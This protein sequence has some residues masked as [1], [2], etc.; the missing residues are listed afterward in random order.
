MSVLTYFNIFVCFSLLT[1]ICAQKHENIESILKDKALASALI[2]ISVKDISSNE[3][4]YEKNSHTQCTPASIFKIITTYAALEKLGADFKFKTEIYYSG[5]IQDSVL[6]GDIIIKGYGDPTIESRFIKSSFFQE[7]IKALQQTGIKKMNGKLR[8]LNNFYQPYI[9]GNWTY[10]DINNYYAAIPYTINIYDNTYSVYFKTYKP[11]Q[12]SDIL[13]IFPQ[14]SKE[15]K[16][17]FKTNRV[18]AKEGGDNAYIYGDPLGYDKRVEG[19]LPPYQNEYSIE[20]ALP[21]PARMFAETFIQ[22]LEKSNIRIRSDAYFI[23]NDTFDIKHLKLIKTI[24]SPSLSHIIQLINLH[25]I[26]LFAEALLYQIGNGSYEAGKKEMIKLTVKYNI[27]K[28]INIDDACG[29]SRLN[30]LSAH[31]MTEWLIKI[32]QSPFQSIFLK[33]LPVAGES[34]TMKNFTDKAPL[35]GNLRCKTGYFERV[36]SYAGYMHTQSGKTIAFCMI[37]NNF[38]ASNEKIKQMSKLFFETLYQQL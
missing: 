16:I 34:G 17:V 24:Y 4:L 38:N 23:S 19:S 21:D 14:Y 10:E 12:P 36:R 7:A 28:E 11:L 37:Y 22:H 32:Y 18:Y 3:I 26:N 15:P 20:G 13:R 35:K 6:D 9:N 2:S 5:N 1:T 27:E 30:G 33:S 29:L 31:A 8:I 25:S